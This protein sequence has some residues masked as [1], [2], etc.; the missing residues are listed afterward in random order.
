MTIQMLP[1]ERVQ[2]TLNFQ[3]PDRIPTAL[4]GGPYGIV[5]EVY[6]KLL[7]YFDLGGPGCAFSAR[8]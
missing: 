6:F 3:E 4:G 5:D 2:K 8:S 1:R 7:E